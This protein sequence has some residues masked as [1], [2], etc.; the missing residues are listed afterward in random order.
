[1]FGVGPDAGQTTFR[2]RFFYGEV[3]AFGAGQTHSAFM[4]FDVS[5]N[6]LDYWWPCGEVFF[7][8]VQVRWMPIRGDTQ[9]TIALERPGSTQDA[10]TLADRIEIQ[11]ISGRFPL[12]DLTGN[13]R[14]GGKRGHIQVSGIVRKTRLDRL[15]TLCTA[16]K[17]SGY[18][19]PILATG[20]MRTTIEFSLASD[21]TLPRKSEV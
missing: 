11:N 12:S 20:F 13:F 15:S 6:I 8:N 2:P 21:T 14:Y 10:G 1:L 19:A 7:R 5:P 18:D 9:L 3:G 16:S 17:R 4:D